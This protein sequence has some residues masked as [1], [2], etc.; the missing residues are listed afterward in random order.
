[1]FEQEGIVDTNAIDGASG[2][3]NGVAGAKVEDE[4]NNNTQGSSGSGGGGMNGNIH[5]SGGPPGTV[6]KCN[7]SIER[8]AWLETTVTRLRTEKEVE[9]ALLRH[10]QLIAEQ[11]ASAQIEKLK[12]DNA[13]LLRRV[14][15]LQSK[16]VEIRKLN[17]QLKALRRQFNALQE[18]EARRVERRRARLERAAFS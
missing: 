10:Q 3:T 12:Q 9:T 7:A 14:H 8:I 16:E 18:M 15:D 2:T 13:L 6:Q 17:L 11:K 1:M 5:S 4:H